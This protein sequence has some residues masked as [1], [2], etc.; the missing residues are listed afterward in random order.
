MV[1]PGGPLL[2][3]SESF[4]RLQ[5]NDLS[6]ALAVAAAAVRVRDLQTQGRAREAICLIFAGRLEE[7]RQR[8]ES[9]RARL[10]AI[11]D[12][13]N[14]DVACYLL[15][16][17]L[18]QWG[19]PRAALVYASALAS[20]S[21]VPPNLNALRWGAEI[22]AQA[23]DRNELSRIVERI[24]EV[25]RQHPCSRSTGILAQVEGLEAAAAGE[26]DRADERCRDA[27]AIWPDISNSWA[28]AGVLTARGRYREGLRE[29][30]SIRDRKGAAIRWQ[31]PVYW[32]ASHAH[33]SRCHR[34]LGEDAQAA[35]SYQ[36]FLYHWGAQSTLPLVREMAAL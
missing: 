2:S 15:G 22:A 26:M 33:A 5:E 34:V 18:A 20:R 30:V 11:G 14:E 31:Q 35:E 7:A 8:L 6:G 4:L 13:A 25:R 1:H 9:E 3:L 12:P 24:S 19:D 23:N 10:Q 16:L 21:A 32:V 17:L 28:W 29:Y 27:C 36:R